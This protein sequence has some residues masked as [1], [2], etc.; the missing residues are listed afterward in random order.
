ML[1]VAFAVS[2]YTVVAPPSTAF[3]GVKMSVQFQYPGR[4]DSA[5]LSAQLR[6]H[7]KQCSLALGPVHRLRCFA[8]ALDAFLAP[9]FVSVL[10]VVTTVVV[11]G[12]SFST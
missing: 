2:D 5:Q 8:E 1:R 10:T 11:V 6:A 4:Q 3:E 12:A 9:R 7:F